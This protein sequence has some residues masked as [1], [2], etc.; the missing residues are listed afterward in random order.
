MV[1][2]GVVPGRRIALYIG[3]GMLVTAALCLLVV[4]VFG[5]Y[6]VFTGAL[7]G[8]VAGAAALVALFA[9]DAIV[10]TESAIYLRKPWHETTIDWDRVVAGRFTLDDRERWSL[11]LDLAGGDE[12]HGELVLLSIP[13]VAGPVSGAY[14][15]RKREQVNEIREILRRKKI[16][17]TVLPE[18]AGAL[19]THW[20]IAPPTR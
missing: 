5:S 7:A 8:V 17:I 2:A 20:K 11:A 3:I 1:R 9:R 16:P 10:L 15:L 12:Q 14:D 18:I 4:A 6:R 19:S 13:P